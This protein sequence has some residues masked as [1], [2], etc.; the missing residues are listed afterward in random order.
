M[1]ETGWIWA[2]RKRMHVYLHTFS[3]SLSSL[4]YASNSYT[5]FVAV[6]IFSI[7]SVLDSE[8]LKVHPL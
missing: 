8:F 4:L 6:M 5:R 3:L 7:T 2:E 1:I